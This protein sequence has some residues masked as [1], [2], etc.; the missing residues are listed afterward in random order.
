[1]GRV[2]RKKS[3]STVRMERVEVL[4]RRVSVRQ[5]PTRGIEDERW[6]IVGGVLLRKID[7]RED[8]AEEV[9]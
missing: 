6:A 9:A 5:D 2:E 4:V 8:I 1:M 7:L 3:R